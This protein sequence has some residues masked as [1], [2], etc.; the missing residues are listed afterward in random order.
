MPLPIY[1][2]FTFT[3][4]LAFIK[5]ICNF[6]AYIT[7][8]HSVIYEDRHTDST[9]ASGICYRNEHFTVETNMI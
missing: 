4:Y 3:V 7:I 6:A 5:L 2:N 1:G 8:N 9:D